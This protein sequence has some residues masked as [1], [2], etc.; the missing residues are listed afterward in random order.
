VPFAAAYSAAKAALHNFTQATST[1]WAPRGIRANAI[2][3][4]TIAHE[5]K[6]RPADVTARIARAIPLGRLGT[7]DEIASIVLFLVSDAASFVT[8]ATLVA[9]GG[10]VDPAPSAA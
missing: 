6:V 7:A 9:G 10:L 2:A 5:S 4:G 1:S 8:G 3:A